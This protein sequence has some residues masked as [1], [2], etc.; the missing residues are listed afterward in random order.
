M[1]SLDR[2]KLL[3]AQGLFILYILASSLAIFIFRII[4]PGEAAPLAC[5][6][7]E[8]RFVKG[9]LNL[10]DLFPALAMTAVVIPF[11]LRSYPP[12][13]FSSFSPNFL[14]SLSPSIFSAI[15][16]TGIYALLFFLVQPLVSNHELNLRTRGRLFELSAEQANYHASMEN[17]SEVERLLNLCESIWPGVPEIV[18]LKTEASIRLTEISQRIDTPSTQ[19]LQDLSGTNPVNATE[20][21][22]MAETAFN[23]ERYYDAHWLATLGA[24]LAGEGSA[25]TAKANRIASEAWD[26]VNSLEPNSQQTEAYE[27]YNLKRNAY[28]AFNSNDYFK[29][30]YL[31]HELLLRSRSDPE[32]QY[33]LRLS[34]EGLNRMAFF[35]DEIEL[36]VNSEAAIFSLPRNTY[37]DERLV[38]YFSSLSVSLDSAYGFD[39]EVLAFDQTGRLLWRMEA[40]YIKILPYSEER[41]SRILMLMRA[42]DKY[43][44]QR[45]FVPLAQSFGEAAPQNAQLILDLSWEDFQLLSELRRGQD[46]LTISELIAAS[47]IS[48]NYGY[49]SQVFDA[50]LISRF[51]EPILLLPFLILVLVIGWRYRVVNKPRYIW[52]PMLVVLP[53]VFSEAVFFF[54]HSLSNISIWA[55]VNFGFSIAIISLGAGTLILFFLS[56][57]ILA[58][59]RG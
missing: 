4:S 49:L 53:L 31:F 38:M 24:G 58:S 3:S 15:A 54:R 44:S 55:V 28:M 5:F 12:E 50:E 18:R 21:I 14:R 34:E 19:P 26:K 48:P 45:S 33:Y 59:Q 43:D 6:Y 2:D 23:E 8:W 57:I 51:A 30:Y 56:L 32:G 40:P 29:A 35:M 52:V 25:E 22:L 11:G 13:K 17:W 7:L 16:A 41:G 47:H 37:G 27:I 10:F 46:R 42:L 36:N 20:A 39:L 1:A 9:A